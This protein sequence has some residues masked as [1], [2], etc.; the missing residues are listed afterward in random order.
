[1]DTP[2]PSAD[3]RPASNDNDQPAAV[4]TSD[5][6]RW[7]RPTSA[8]VARDLDVNPV[9]GL[10]SDEVARR[11]EVHGR[12]ELAEPPR[13]PGWL[14]FLDQFRNL[15]VYV[16]LGAAVLSAAVG[17]FKDPV[18]ILIVLLINAV[19][20][21]VQEH[22]ADDA[23]DALRKMLEL[24]VRVR[25]NGEVVEVPAAELVPGDLVLLEAGDRIP[26]DGRFLVA[27]SLSVDESTLTGESVPVDKDDRPVTATGDVPLAERHNL[28][29]MNTTVVRG[30]AEMVVTET[31]METVVGQLAGV[32]GSTD[33]P[34][35]PLQEQLDKLGKRL[36]LIAG[37]AVLVVFA[38]GLAQ[39]DEL[40]EAVLGAVALAVAAIPEG[41]PAVVTVTLAIGVSRMAKHHAIVKRLASVETL[42][43]TTVICSDKTGTLTLN[44]MTATA[45]A[46]RG[47]MF[48]V[49]GLGYG[50]DGT[51]RDDDGPVTDLGGLEAA[52]VA[53]VLCNDAHL[54]TDDEG[55][56]AIVG[57]PTEAALVVLAAKAGLDP[58]QLRAASPRVGE[59]PFDSATKFMATLHPAGPDRSLVVV[60]GAPDVVLGRCATVAGPAGPEQLEA[61]VREQAVAANDAL[62]AQGLRVLAVA[63]RELPVSAADY[64]GDLA[65]EVSDLDLQMLVGILD[66]ARPEAVAAIAECH[67]AGIAVKMITGDHASTAGAIAAQ[68]GVK[69]RVVTGAD[70]EAMSDE[71]LAAQVHD[72]GVCARVSPQHKVR[73][74]TAL[75]SLG[76][77]VA[78]TGDG[79]NDAAS[80]RQAEIGVAMGITGTEVTKEAGDMILADDNFATIV[81]AV[82]RGRAIY[83]NIVTFVRFQLAT[84][85][86]ALSAILLT[87]LL[88]YPAIF[89]PIQVL[90]VNI[91]ADGPPAMSLGV[92]PPKPGVMDRAPRDRNERI[93]SGRRLVRICWTAAVMV[94]LTMWVFLS[95]DPTT[96]PSQVAG[97]SAYTLAFTL[98]VFLQMAN[99]LCVRAGDLSLFN[100]YTLTNRTLLVS[101]AAIVASQVVIVQVP[102]FEKI[103][104][105]VPLTLAEWRTAL[106]VPLV[107]IGVEEVRKVGVRLVRRR[108]TPAEVA[109]LAVPVA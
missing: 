83:D 46:A 59:V 14:K 25:R 75:Q 72:I 30:R 50:T 64:S 32:L 76:E 43:S 99:A 77:V 67:R 93:L 57:D 4:L 97:D 40:S 37:V 86:S 58:E 39:G 17:D 18:I 45:L 53:G 33:N 68:L 7:F 31:G 35:T 49:D 85:I 105:T 90:F 48:A 69:G 87:R 54:T 26:A 79:V 3:D 66:P 100:R 82:E 56:P 22:R 19:L 51:V 16:L 60:K 96:K 8:E 73:V 44:Q 107:F 29:H 5:E 78:M 103:F 20:G 52:L 94:A 84:N 36:A 109:E 42:G 88:G 108:R 80:L 13:R 28:G 102:F 38:V 10:S 62:G 9:D 70:L 81:E 34:I 55:A 106:L 71:E 11:L 63:T 91:I 12:N 65:D 95:H 23:L 2:P 1:M 98:F 74:V 21:Y 27:A 89:N 6:G 104:E 92:D 61:S 41:L 24:I 101:V 15:L 47:Q